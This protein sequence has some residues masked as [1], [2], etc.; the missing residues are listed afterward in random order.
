MGVSELLWGENFDLFDVAGGWGFGRSTQDHYT[1][2]VEIAKLREAEA[3]ETHMV[4]AR[5]APL[6][7][8]PDI[9]APVASEL[10]FGAR[11][12]GVQNGRFLAING[13]G[14]VHQR[15]LA[16][17]PRTPL[18][19]ARR[20]TGAPYLWGGRT[21]LGVDCSGLVQVALTACGTPS[22]RD[23]DQQRDE[24]GTPVDFA[25]RRGGDLIF[26]PGHVGILVDADTLFH[27]NAYWMTTVEEPLDDV[28]ARMDADGSG[29]GVT[30][31]RRI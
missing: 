21:P 30:G 10:P 29:G 4:T 25:D 7:C 20:F 12:A 23:S 8:A 9:K 2:W 17:L 3:G 15:H 24:L 22:P 19:I 1:G 13:S 27:A 5:L 11:I 31:V 14:F 18:A 16:P 6:F 26:F 28:I